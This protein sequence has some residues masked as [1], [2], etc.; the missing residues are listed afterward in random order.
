MSR[1]ALGKIF[2]VA[3]CIDSVLRWKLKNSELGM[4][5]K[6]RDMRGSYTRLWASDLFKESR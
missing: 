4:K 5:S 6:Q 3:I 2:G 1:D